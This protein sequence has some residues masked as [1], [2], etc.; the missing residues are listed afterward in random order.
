[1]S[2]NRLPVQN[3]NTGIGHLRVGIDAP[4]MEGKV[5]R[6]AFCGPVVGFVEMMS[7]LQKLFLAFHITAFREK[8]IRR[9]ALQV[10][11]KIGVQFVADRHQPFR[12][13][14]LEPLVLA[15]GS[16]AQAFHV[17]LFDNV[18]GIQLRQFS[19][20]A[21]GVTR[22]DGKHSP[23]FGVEKRASRH[24]QI[25][26]RFHLPAFQ[27]AFRF[28][29]R[30]DHIHSD[31][32]ID[33]LFHDLVVDGPNKDAFQHS[34]DVFDRVGIHRPF[35]GLCGHRARFHPMYRGGKQGVPQMQNILL[36]DEIGRSVAVENRADRRYGRIVFAD[37]RRRRIGLP[38]VLHE[39]VADV[40][41]A[42]RLRLILPSAHKNVEPADVRFDVLSRKLD[43][44][45]DLLQQFFHGER[46]D[47]GT[48]IGVT[49]LDRLIQVGCVERM[50]YASDLEPFL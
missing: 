45:P 28:R 31:D 13:V 23:R 2:E 16:D 5:G 11:F 21:P 43:V 50:P 26:E 3:V 46:G 12:T 38:V 32:G 22:H 47:D 14:G 42:Y 17:V 44:M 27:R 25:A 10:A 36:V 1:M 35:T 34:D 33:A 39:M 37:R 18:F 6:N 41:Q 40:F 19:H 8:P 48:Q 4:T 15:E 30:L 20:P 9:M 29:P 7:R 24:R 49:Q